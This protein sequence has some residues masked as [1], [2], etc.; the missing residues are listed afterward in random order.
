MRRRRAELVLPGL[1]LAACGG[2]CH[3]AAPPEAPGAP[4]APARSTSPGGDYAAPPTQPSSPDSD[5]SPSTKDD[6]DL[7]QAMPTLDDALSAFDQAQARLSASGN[8][9]HTACRA[10]GSMRRSADRICE[11]EPEEPGNR[12]ERARRRLRDAEQRVHDGCGAC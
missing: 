1:L 3:A 10:L 9:C 6:R 7:E 4:E 11:L 8:D 5:A 2:A 12:C